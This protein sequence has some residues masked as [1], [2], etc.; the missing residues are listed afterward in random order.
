[1]ENSL[2]MTSIA[3]MTKTTIKTFDVEWA[4]ANPTAHKAVLTLKY[5]QCGCLSFTSLVRWTSL[6]TQP[7]SRRLNACTAFPA[8]FQASSRTLTTL[9]SCPVCSSSV[10]SVVMP[11]SHW[12]FQ[13]RRSS[14]AWLCS[15]L[16]CPT[17]CS[18]PKLTAFQGLNKPTEH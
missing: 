2:V 11:I 18:A 7:W 9:G 16:R 5:L 13:L 12:C 14:A 4:H 8:R 1:M 6:T 17:W 15:A 10:T 3:Q